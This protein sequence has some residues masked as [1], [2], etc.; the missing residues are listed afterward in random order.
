MWHWDNEYLA[1]NH[2]FVPDWAFGNQTGWTI[3]SKPLILTTS[4]S[5]VWRSKNKKCVLIRNS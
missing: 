1:L 5:Y 4:E 3:E 2:K